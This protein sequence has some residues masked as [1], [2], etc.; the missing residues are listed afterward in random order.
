MGHLARMQT[1]LYFPC[2]WLPLFQIECSC[3]SFHMKM[4]WFSREWMNR[5]H[6]FSFVQREA[7]VNSEL[8]YSSMS[9]HR[10]LWYVLVRIA[11]FASY[12][13]D[14]RIIGFIALKDLKDAET[15]REDNKALYMRTTAC[16]NHCLLLIV[17]MSRHLW[18]G[19]L[20]IWSAL[21]AAYI[22]INRPTIN[23]ATK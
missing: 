18:V 3:K 19:W 4:T 17:L 12:S 8:A 10:G 11:S 16:S 6:T 9:C 20:K 2:W 13:S 22:T 21:P 15:K 23:S 7:K 14:L 5:W 1:S